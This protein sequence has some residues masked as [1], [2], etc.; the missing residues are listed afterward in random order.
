MVVP[1]ENVEATITE[2]IDAG[3]GKGTSSLIMEIQT[4]K[5]VGVEHYI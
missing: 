2:L 1:A 3:A 4:S 5:T